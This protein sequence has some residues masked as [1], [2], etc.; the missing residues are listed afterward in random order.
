MPT[1]LNTKGFKFIIFTDDHPPP[2]IHVKQAEGGTKIRLEP[3]EIIAYWSLTPRQLRAI[4]TITR[5]NRDYFLSKWYE[6][7][8]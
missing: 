6:L 1:I 5:E 8:G 4:M 3:V 2:H 7:H